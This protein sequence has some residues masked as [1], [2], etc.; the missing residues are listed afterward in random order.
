MMTCPDPIPSD[1]ETF[2]EI[3]VSPPPP[4]FVLVQSLNE[5]GLLSFPT[6]LLI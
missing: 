6:R 1:Y 2:H 3:Q 5:T 4:K